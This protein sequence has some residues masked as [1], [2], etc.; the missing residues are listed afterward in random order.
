MPDVIDAPAPAE[1]KPK[2]ADETAELRKRF[3]IV[4]EDDTDLFDDVAPAKP[5]AKA[6]PKVEPEPEPEPEPP[7]APAKPKHSR[8]LVSAARQV[9]L[10]DDDLEDASPEDIRL[11]IQLRQQEAVERAKT[12]KVKAEEPEEEFDWGEIEDDD[13]PGKTR[14]IREDEVAPGIVKNIK[15]Q[16]ARTRKIEAALAEVSRSAQSSEQAKTYAR[17]DA[18]FAGLKNPLFGSGPVDALT[19]GGPE[20]ARRNMVLNAALRMPSAKAD[21]EAC[22]REA[23]KVFAIPTAAAPKAETEAEREWKDAG[24]ARPTSRKPVAEPKGTKAAEKAVAKKLGVPYVEADDDDN[25]Y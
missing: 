15:A 21:L 7:P 2:P 25:E 20:H 18:V 1:A 24:L 10:T 12:A 6:A 16:A 8:L 17:I 23:A 5:A 9:G 22:I 19:P 13:N 4:D 11:A 3:E 14:K